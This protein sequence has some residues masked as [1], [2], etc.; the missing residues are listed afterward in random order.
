MQKHF[1]VRNIT[2]IGVLA[3]LT[4]AASAISFP[5]PTAS[6]ATRIHPGNAMCLLAGMILGPIPGALAAGIGSMFYSLSNPLHAPYALFTLVFK[7]LMGYVCGV[8]VW[9]G[10]GLH[11]SS[12]RV[13]YIAAFCGIITYYVLHL[14][15]SFLEDI[16]FKHMEMETALAVLSTRLVTSGINGAFAVIAAPL[17][18]FAIRKALDKTGI[19]L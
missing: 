15:R 6:E 2:L 3:A 18:A 9:R 10:G 12:L 7:G 11:L 19:R 14:G 17:L 8:I 1:T 16:Y 13:H 4:F 5:V